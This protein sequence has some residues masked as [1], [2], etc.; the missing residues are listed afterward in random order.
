MVTLPYFESLDLVNICC[1]TE[2]SV[3]IEKGNF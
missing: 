1:L 3:T 2:E